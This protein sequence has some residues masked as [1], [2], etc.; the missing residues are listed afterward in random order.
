M[1]IHNNVALPNNS[2]ILRE[3]IGEGDMALCCSIPSDEGCGSGSSPE[4]YFPNKTKVS[5][6]GTMY[7]TDGNGLC[8]NR[9]STDKSPLG[10]YCCLFLDS[11][12]NEQ[13]ICAKVGEL[14]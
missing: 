6:E 8:L 13:I 2:A 9:Q 1:F 4:I 3:E 12:D 10:V 7:T 5:G 11:E 14:R